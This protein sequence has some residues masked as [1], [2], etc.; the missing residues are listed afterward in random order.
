M[1]RQFSLRE[2]PLP[3]GRPSRANIH[4]RLDEQVAELRARSSR[5]W[6]DEYLARRW[7]RGQQ[8]N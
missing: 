2:G 4:A 3:R 1:T 5:Q 6:V 7:S 8:G